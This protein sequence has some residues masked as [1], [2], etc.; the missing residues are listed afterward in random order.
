YT[1]DGARVAETTLTL[2]EIE[3]PTQLSSFV[4]RPS[5]SGVN[6]GH[7]LSFTEARF[8][9]ATARPGDTVTVEVEFLAL[10]PITED[11]IVNVT[12]TGEGW[13][14]QVDT[15]PVGGALPTLKWIT[16]SRI[17]DRYTLTIP[18]DSQLGPATLTLN[19]Y[20]AFTQRNL[21]VLD[22]DLA[23]RGPGIPLGIVKV[24]P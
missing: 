3:S 14:A 22:R 11:L 19:W 21:P 9:P 12:L 7:R 5:S 20:D 18:K 24:V 8:T 23:Q 16:G 6:F 17:R 2:I 1:S 4:L 13:R 10:R 15:A